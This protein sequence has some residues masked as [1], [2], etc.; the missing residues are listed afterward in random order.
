MLNRPAAA[1]GQRKP[2]RHDK[3][4]CL[5]CEKDSPFH[6]EDI[7]RISALRSIFSRSIENLLSH[8]YMPKYIRTR[9][10][11]QLFASGHGQCIRKLFEEMI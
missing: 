3:D 11:G 9:D 2:T 7:V 10:R 8:G 5:S 4:V 1:A 6:P